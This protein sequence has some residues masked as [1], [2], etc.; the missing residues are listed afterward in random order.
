M[1][2]L[3]LWKDFFLKMMITHT[4]IILPENSRSVNHLILATDPPGEDMGGT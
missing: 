3:K 2:I 4:P 1:S